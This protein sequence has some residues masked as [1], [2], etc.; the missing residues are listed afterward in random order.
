MERVLKATANH[1]TGTM[2]TEHVKELLAMGERIQQCSQDLDKAA[3]ELKDKLTHV[4]ELVEDL[5]RRDAKRK[6]RLKYMGYLQKAFCVLAIL[7]AAAALIAGIVFAF[8]ATVP[9]IGAT[10]VV[11]T[12]GTGAT[13]ASAASKFF[14]DMKSSEDTTL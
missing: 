8:P 4:L 5:Q 9:V 3:V 12:L 7:L 14:R 1:D 2:N 11:A 13:M 6:L 10:I